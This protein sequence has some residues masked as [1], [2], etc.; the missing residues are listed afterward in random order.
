VRQQL[1]VLQPDA[2]DEDARAAAGHV[3]GRAP[4]RRQ[5]RR[6][7]LQ[8]QALLRVHQRCL[9]GRQAEEDRVEGVHVGQVG[10]KA[11][12]HAAALR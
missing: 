1:G 11:R 10:A 9:G 8:Q 5:R 7:L 3:P 6:Q 12:R 2:A 4:G